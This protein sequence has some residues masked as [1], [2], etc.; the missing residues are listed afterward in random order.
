[1]SNESWVNERVGQ[2]NVRN[3]KYPIIFFT[4]KL[5]IVLILET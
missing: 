5:S 1:M 3:I 4:K 2:M